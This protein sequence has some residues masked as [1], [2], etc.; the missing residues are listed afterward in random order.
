MINICFA[1]NKYYNEEMEKSTYKLVESKD[2][3]TT[4]Q[5]E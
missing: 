5:T 2:Y 1:K 3:S 4:K